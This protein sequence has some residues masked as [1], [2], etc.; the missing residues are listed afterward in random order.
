[1]KR[2][3]RCLVVLAVLTT[4]VVT[5]GPALAK[6]EKC[7]DVDNQVVGTADFTTNTVEGT[8]VGNGIFKGGTAEGAFAFTSVDPETGTAT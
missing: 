1:M 6:D 7:R 5:A 8:V 2:I 3:A 4:G